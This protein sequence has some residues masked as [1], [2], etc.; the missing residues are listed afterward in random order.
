MPWIAIGAGAWTVVS[1]AVGVLIGRGITRAD[2]ER[3]RLL[4]SQGHHPSGRALRL[5]AS[6]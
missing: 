1:I 4:A 6:R 5:V 2:H 3:E